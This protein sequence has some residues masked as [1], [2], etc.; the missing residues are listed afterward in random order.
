MDQHR[1]IKGVSAVDSSHV[2]A[3][4]SG[5]ILF[6]DG[7]KWSVQ[8]EAGNSSLFQG[9][10]GVYALDYNHVWAVGSIQSG[11]SSSV[12]FF[13]GRKWVVQFDKFGAGIANT[14]DPH[15]KD[16]IE[17]LK[18]VYASSPEKV[19]AETEQAVVINDRNEWHIRKAP[20][21]FYS[22]LSGFENK[23]VG[24]G[25]LQEHNNLTNRTIYQA[26]VFNLP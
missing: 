10:N 6:F 18:A 11:F 9:L 16:Y 26:A 7:Q 4:G 1:N 24:V 14:P 8:W 5:G 15:V 3:V 25:W 23:V 17:P 20:N 13:D 19:Y 2:W 21:E 22:A 12:L